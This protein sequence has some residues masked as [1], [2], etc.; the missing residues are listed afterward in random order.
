MWVLA[1]LGPV[2]DASLSF[3][4]RGEGIITAAE[5]GRAE[6]DAHGRDANDASDLMGHSLPPSMLTLRPLLLRPACAASS[7][8]LSSSRETRSAS[9]PLQMFRLGQSR[10]RRRGTARRGA[11]SARVITT[12]GSRTRTDGRVR[13]DT[14]TGC[15]SVH[16]RGRPTSARK[17]LMAFQ[18]T[19]VFILKS[20]KSNKFLCV[21]MVPTLSTTRKTTVARATD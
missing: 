15:R 4:G 11:H 3:L 1:L 9:G 2:S 5:A 19:C 21:T 10:R 14:V 7:M 6:D 16:G 8:P 18:K 17:L 20:V 13:W 12:S